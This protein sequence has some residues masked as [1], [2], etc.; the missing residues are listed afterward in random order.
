MSERY[1][2]L[3]ALPENIYTHGAPVMI[4]AG[5]LLKDNQT[6]NVLGQF[7]FRNIST[8]TVKALKI[9]VDAFDISGKEL[10]GVAEYQYLDLSAGRDSEFGQKQAVTMPDNVTR[11]VNVKCTS[12]IFADGSIWNAPESAEWESLPVQEM[13]ND[14]LGE[15]AEQYK[16]DT[17]NS[18]RFVPKDT[19]DLWLCACGAVNRDDEDKCHSCRKEKAV[20]IAALDRDTL[21]K[22]KAEY[23][24][25][26]AEKKVEQ[27]RIAKKTKAKVK[28]IGIIA[29]A[30]LLVIIGAFV[31]LYTESIIPQR[32]YDAAMELVNN[33]QFDEAIAVFS[34]LDDYKD[35][36]KW[37]NAKNNY[38]KA[39]NLLKE[40]VTEC[41]ELLKEV[42]TE[43]AEANEIREQCEKYIPYCGIFKSST[44]PSNTFKSDFKVEQDGSAYWLPQYADGSDLWPFAV[45]DGSS[46]RKLFVTET[47]EAGAFEV[48]ENMRAQFSLREFK[49]YMRFENGLM[50]YDVDDVY[51]SAGNLEI[52][53]QYVKAD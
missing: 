1:S 3:V 34:E 20:L 9:A 28:K 31:L 8:K 30:V 37:V 25:V 18:A 16:R 19:D 15:L 42:P 46:V 49:A 13:L 50:T 2:R 40:S 51:A 36:A 33:G 22:N 52:R 7:K 45:Q 47:G 39:K 6:G 29:A 24:K 53:A 11:S 48:D 26:C 41:Y 27:E 5:A 21:E 4:A 43:Y 10:A 17:V 12:V 35:S 23:D 38:S 44:N 32:K 14:K